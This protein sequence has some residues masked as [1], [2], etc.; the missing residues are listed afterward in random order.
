MVC[1]RLL[2]YSYFNFI[3][4]AI[5]YRVSTFICNFFCF[6][7][8]RKCDRTKANETPALF[9]KSKLVKGKL[10]EMTNLFYL[11]RSHFYCYIYSMTASEEEK[12]N[13]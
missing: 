6:S 1:K 7:H 9:I 4:I 8:R 2:L 10:F 13:R 3:N 12:R 5:V 11:F